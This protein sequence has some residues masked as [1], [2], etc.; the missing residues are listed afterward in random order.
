MSDLHLIHPAEPADRPLITI[1]T[2]TYNAAATLPPTLESVRSQ[3]FDRFE[4]LIIDGASTDGTLDIARR[5]AH[6]WETVISE[7]D[8][9]LYD[10]MNKGLDRARG[11]YVMFLNAGDTLHAPDT[12]SRIARVIL[13]NDF[14]GVVY[15]QTDIV[16]CSRHRVA[17]RHL[18][19]PEHLTLKS[20]AEGM[21][22]CHQAFIALK[23]I[24]G[25]FDLSYRFSADYEWCI[26]VL[27][28]SRNNVMVPGVLIDYLAE[29][30]TTRNRRASLAERFRI[31]S[32]Y[33]GFWPTLWRHLGFIPRFLKRRRLE[34]KFINN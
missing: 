3:D 29:G 11:D 9:G 6:P 33:Y 25:P 4:H 22:V 16:D 30:V 34:K 12:L 10:A 14:P 23:R 13:D 28:H 31:M 26:R 8:R 7:R 5:D 18:E 19:A 24:T 1:V 20:F 27:Q 21:V 17:G 32:R 15:G 2:V